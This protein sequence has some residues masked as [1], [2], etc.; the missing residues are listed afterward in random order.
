M[1]DEKPMNAGVSEIELT[2]EMMKAG[3]R[4]YEERD[5]RVQRPRD[6]V[7]DIFLSMLEAS[8]QAKPVYST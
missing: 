5:S 3:I 7:E 6:I 4:A 1:S 2:P 8:Q